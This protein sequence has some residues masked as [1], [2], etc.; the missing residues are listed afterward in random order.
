LIE[1]LYKY[2]KQNYELEKINLREWKD[3]ER[4]I[5]RLCSKKV[6]KSENRKRIER[7]IKNHIIKS[8]IFYIL[9]KK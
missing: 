5:K 4:Y 8:S 3:V 6:C 2:L 9:G 1:E 7:N